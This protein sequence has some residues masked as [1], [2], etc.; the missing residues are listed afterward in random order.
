[1]PKFGRRSRQML[2]TAH[3]DLQKVFDEVIRHID[4]SVLQGKRGKEEQD[5][6]Y[7]QGKSKVQ[8]PNSKHNSD[9]SLAVDVVPY[10]I[11]WN[12]RKRFYH[13]A[14]FV[15]GIASQMNIK[16]RWGG[17][18]DSDMDFNDQT[19]FDLPHYELGGKV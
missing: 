6:L 19:F 5:E 4:C 14:G 12:D 1:M 13:L 17:D 8:Y 9:L 15:M 18:W 10:P 16:I 11:D 2:Y 3:E 7:R